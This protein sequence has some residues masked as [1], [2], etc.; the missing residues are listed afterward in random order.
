M[1]L[2]LVLEVSRVGAAYDPRG[3]T[4]ALCVNDDTITAKEYTMAKHLRKARTRLNARRND[5]SATIND[6]N[7]T[8]RSSQKE[9]A[10]TGGYRM[11]GSMK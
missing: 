8:Y 7:A 5:H 10:M 3:A 6:N 4:L 11:P 1:T 2:W 9:R